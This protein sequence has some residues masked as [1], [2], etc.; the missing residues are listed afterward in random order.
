MYK[1]RIIDN[2]REACILSYVFCNH[3]VGRL[4]LALYLH[5]SLFI[6]RGKLLYSCNSTRFTFS[7]EKFLFSLFAAY[8]INESLVGGFL[9]AVSV[10]WPRTLSQKIF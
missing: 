8:P 6:L 2:R 3:L 10:Q 7:L 4:V 5:C 1:F 9:T